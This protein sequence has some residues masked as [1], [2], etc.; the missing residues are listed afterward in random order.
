MPIIILQP[1]LGLKF[2]EYILSK[3]VINVRI[4]IAIGI[5]VSDKNWIRF[6]GSILVQPDIRR[7][8]PKQS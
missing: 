1:Y 5:D 6:S 4:H 8:E 3:L 2:C 7:S